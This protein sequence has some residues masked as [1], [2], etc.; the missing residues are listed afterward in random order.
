MIQEILTL[1]GEEEEID[2]EETLEGMI[3]EEIGETLEEMIEEEEIEIEEILEEMIE[4]EGIEI[5]ET[6]EEM[7]DEE[8]IEI[9]EMIEEEMEIEMV[10]NKTDL[11]IEIEIVIEIINKESQPTFPEQIK[12][13]SFIICKP[14]MVFFKTHFNF[15]LIKSNYLSTFYSFFNIS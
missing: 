7:I 15:Q 1:I 3:E 13:Y 11:E 14:P 12:Q 4:E 8:G 9:E 6:L 2:I 5:E 10:I